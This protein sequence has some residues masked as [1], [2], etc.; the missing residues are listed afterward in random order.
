MVADLV[1]ARRWDEGN[2][3]LQQFARGYCATEAPAGR[4]LAGS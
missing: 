4:V 2:Q 1:R 3:F